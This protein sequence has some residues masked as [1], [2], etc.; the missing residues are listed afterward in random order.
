MRP[1][2]RAGTA[3]QQHQQQQQQQSQQPGSP[4]AGAEPLQG[5]LAVS[6][7]GHHRSKPPVAGA[8]DRSSAAVNKAERFRKAATALLPA[9]AQYDLSGEFSAKQRPRARS[10]AWCR[11]KP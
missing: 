2:Q 4:A 7:R 3:S 6:I 5:S 11:C 8:D 1:S 10:S 9:L